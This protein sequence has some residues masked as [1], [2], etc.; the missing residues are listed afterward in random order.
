MRGELRDVL[1]R[2][3]LPNMA[4]GELRDVLIWQLLPNRL[5][6]F[7]AAREGAQTFRNTVQGTPAYMAPEV[8]QG[9]AHRGA[10]ADV[11]SLAGS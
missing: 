6:D 10:A 2:Q 11:W 1:I 3:L 8:A 9:H 7:G 5:V 4:A